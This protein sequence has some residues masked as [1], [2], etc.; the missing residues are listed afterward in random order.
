MGHG[1]AA[2]RAS[3]LKPPAGTAA[4]APRGNSRSPMLT[5]SGGPKPHNSLAAPLGHAAHQGKHRP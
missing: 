1:P 3:S 4:G 2:S 5:Q